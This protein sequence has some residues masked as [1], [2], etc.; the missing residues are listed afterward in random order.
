MTDWHK[1]QAVKQL[2]TGRFK[3]SKVSSRLFAVLRAHSDS[4][5][6]HMRLIVS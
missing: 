1:M 5:H 4:M 2:F 3:E 6:S